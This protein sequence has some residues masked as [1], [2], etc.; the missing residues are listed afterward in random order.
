MTTRIFFS[1]NQLGELSERQLQLMLERW[2]L[3]KLVAA[4]KTAKGVGNQTMF[5]DSTAGR[6]VLK[7]NPLYPGQFREEQYYVDGL[8]AAGL[9]VPAPYLVDEATDIFGWPYALMPRLAGDHI[10]DST[11]WSGLG[12]A[13]RQQIA[14]L[15]GTSLSRL[16]RWQ[17][18]QAGEYDPITDNVSPFPHSYRG[19]LF[20]RIDYWL[21]DA[22]R[23]SQVTAQDWEWVNQLLASARAAFDQLTTASYVMGDFK[24]DNLLVR[25]SDSGWELA[26][27]FDFTNGYFGDG[28]ADLC[29]LVIMHLSAGEAEL[30]KRFVVAYCRGCAETTGFAARLRV[31]LLQQCVLNWGCAKAIGQ[32]TWDPQL[33]FASW[34]AQYVGAV[35]ELLP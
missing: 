5:V 29:K 8:R 2:Q 11:F 24:A 15:L 10:S 35:D 30:A 17:V 33:S 20:D 12:E 23:Y 14:E 1:T 21:R 25:R 13:D 6:F 31:H 18:P 26:G 32:A 16:H 19:W 4:G 22:A 27:I 34:A 9:P 3:G 28:L 7:G